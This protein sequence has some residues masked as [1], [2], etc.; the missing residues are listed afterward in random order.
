[1]NFSLS[2]NCDTLAFE[3]DL[4]AAVEKLLHHVAR[5]VGEHHGLSGVVKDRNGCPVG[6]WRLED[7]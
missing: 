6:A 4:E 7:V 5:R 1:M 2:F 3:K